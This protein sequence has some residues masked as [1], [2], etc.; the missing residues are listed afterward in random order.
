[1]LGVLLGRQTDLDRQ[2]EVLI[3]HTVNK[4]HAIGHDVSTKWRL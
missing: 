2:H 1:M 3:R 4:A